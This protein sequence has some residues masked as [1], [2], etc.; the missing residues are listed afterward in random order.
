MKFGKFFFFVIILL[1]V[2]VGSVFSAGEKAPLAERTILMAGVPTYLDRFDSFLLYSKGMEEKLNARNVKYNYVLRAPG[3]GFSDHTGQR[4]IYEDM[5]ALGVDMI[6][7]LPTSIEIQM[8]AYR[9]IADEYNV[10]LIITDYLSFP[11]GAEIPKNMN[12]VW[13]AS[14]SH[15]D[16][17]IAVADYIKANYPKGTKIVVIKGIPGIISDERA[18]N[19]LHIA[20]GME[21]IYEHWAD[22]DREKAYVGAQNALS[23]YPD[24]E[25]ILG[26]NS[27]MAIGIVKA[28]EDAGMLGKVDVIG[29]GGIIEE[30]SSIA[31]GK[32]KATAARN[33]FD[34]GEYMAEVVLAYRDGY[35]DKLEH[36]FQTPITVYDSKQSILDNIDPRYLELFKIPGLND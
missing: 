7:T 8:S 20:N 11:E 6:L 10:P 31:Q 30:L 22:F 9:M 16:M 2:V 14:Y 13:F 18:S 28:V 24:V 4:T 26:C 34:V 21:I 12:N 32:L 36:V 15:K 27:T 25:I 5:L 19:E 35:T 33:H 1:L 3:G 23:A 17:G 29:F